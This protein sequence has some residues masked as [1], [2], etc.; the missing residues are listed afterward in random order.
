MTKSTSKDESGDPLCTGTVGFRPL[1]TIVPPQLSVLL[2]RLPDNYICASPSLQELRQIIHTI[3][4]AL[5][6]GSLPSKIPISSAFSMDAVAA[7]M[8]K[9]RKK[10]TKKKRTKAFLDLQ[11]S[12]D[13]SESRVHT[14]LYGEKEEQEEQEEQEELAN[15]IYDF[16]LVKVCAI[17]VGDWEREWL[18]EPN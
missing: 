18:C 12:E 9:P 3:Y 8:L 14:R 11:D 5:S 4:D 13:K 17:K 10:A 1:K 16:F 7:G 2:T 15:A 6:H